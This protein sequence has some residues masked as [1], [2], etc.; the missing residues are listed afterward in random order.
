[1]PGQEIT[2]NYKGLQMENLKSRQDI[3]SLNYGFKCDCELCRKEFIIND[4]ERYKT[5]KNLQQQAQLLM[6]KSNHHFFT[7]SKRLEM[8]QNEILCYKE[9]YK[10]VQ[11]RNPTRFIPQHIFVIDILDDGFRAGVQGYGY[12]KMKLDKS[13]KKYFEEEC[14][15]FSKVGLQLSEIV[16]GIDSIMTKD[17]QERN[18]NFEKCI[19]ENPEFEI[20]FLK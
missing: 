20:P 5:F 7:Y 9:M 6:E 19:V 11:I 17:W 14:Q 13:N 8:I 4:D 12:A 15:N 1:M 3:F 10:L 18:C 16:S 2:I